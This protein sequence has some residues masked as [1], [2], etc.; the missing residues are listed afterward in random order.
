M[1]YYTAT[2]QRKLPGKGN[3]YRLVFVRARDF[4][5]AQQQLRPSRFSSWTVSELAYSEVPLE[6]HPTYIH[7]SRLMADS[8]Y[9]YAVNFWN[10][11]EGEA[12]EERH[13]YVQARSWFEAEPMFAGLKIPGWIR[14]EHFFVEPGSDWFDDALPVSEFPKGG[15]EWRE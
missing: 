12:S 14:G 1:H 8:M 10:Q 6:D 4:E 2:C 3:D 5:D 9:F 7:I 13:Y 15:T 11:Q